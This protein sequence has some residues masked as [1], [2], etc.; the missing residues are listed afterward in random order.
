VVKDL[1]VF[2]NQQDDFSVQEMQPLF[3][4]VGE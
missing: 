1:L 2:R 3:K 4:G